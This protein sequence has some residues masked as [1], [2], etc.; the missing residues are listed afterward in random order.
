MA[1][2]LEGRRSQRHRRSPHSHDTALGSKTNANQ[3]P[4]RP[5]LLTSKVFQSSR[6]YTTPH[7]FVASI[8]ANAAPVNATGRTAAVSGVSALRAVAQP[9]GHGQTR[10]AAL[11]VYSNQQWSEEMWQVRALR[12][13][14]ARSGSVWS[15]A[16]A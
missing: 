16:A 4:A 11:T 1:G 2:R 12:A 5:C 3:P 13:M 9:R 15:R 6:G 14:R 7:E 8:T 10:K